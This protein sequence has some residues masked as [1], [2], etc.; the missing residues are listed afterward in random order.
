MQKDV[1]IVI[2]GIQNPERREIR[3]LAMKM[4]AEYRAQWTK[5]STH[6]IAAISGTDKQAEAESK[7]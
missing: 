4:G 3:E 6:L 2:S 1:V 7:F 5:D